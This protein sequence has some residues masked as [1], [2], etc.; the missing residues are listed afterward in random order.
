MEIVSGLQCFGCFENRHRVSR[1]RSADV[2][3]VRYSDLIGS[4]KQNRPGRQI[5]R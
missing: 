4:G 5:F 1:V 3:S 2:S